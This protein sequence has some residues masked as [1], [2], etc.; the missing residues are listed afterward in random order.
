[1]SLGKLFHRTIRHARARLGR[2]APRGSRRRAALALVYGLFDRF[3]PRHLPGWYSLWPTRVPPLANDFTRAALQAF[4]AQHW[5]RLGSP[6]TTPLNPGTAARAVVELLLGRPDLRRRFPRSLQQGRDG[7]LARWLLGEE[8]RDSGISSCDAELMVEALGARPG[9]RILHWYDNDPNLRSRFPLARTPVEAPWFFFWLLNHGDNMPHGL[10]EDDG[11]G[12]LVDA[13]EDPAGG[14]ADSYLRQPLWQRM[15]PH[16]LTRFGWDELKAWVARRYNIAGDWL[17]EAERPDWLQ[18]AEE[19]HWLTV[20]RPELRARF[21]DVIVNPAS[22]RALAE[23][24][25]EQGAV[26]ADWLVRL[27]R[28]PPR[29]GVNVLAHFRYPSG[30]QVAAL[31]VL[32]G[33]EQA[34]LHPSRRDVPVSVRTDLPGRDGFLDLQPYPVSL[35]CLAPEP[36]AEDCY[37]RA[38]LAMRPG[39]YRIGYW[40]WELEEVPRRWRLHT[41]WLSE[42]W[43]PTRFVGDA[44]RRVMPLPVVDMLAGMRMPPVVDVPRAE[45]GLPKDRFL[46][47]FIFDMSSTF[48]R[49][50]PMAVVEAFRRAFPRRDSVALAVKVTR[51]Q[52]DPESL[53]KLRE[54]CDQVG[55]TLIDAMLSHEQLF[56]LINSCDAYVSLHRSEGYGLTMAEA[57]ALGKP[58]IA[59]GY[60]GNLDFMNEQNSLLVPYKKVAVRTT[61]HIYRKGCSWAEPSVDDAAAMM[62][63]VVDNPATAAQIAERG[64][65]D[66]QQ[67][68]S[69]EAAGRRMASRLAELER[70]GALPAAG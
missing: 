41:R 19:L 44:L 11:L 64:R 29:P 56:G 57:M 31:N 30:L 48:D 13:L 15:V 69:L 25:H 26:D 52:S 1:M 58:V 61:V 23:H 53:K 22:A 55:A 59:T 46:F 34:G 68:L 50:N 70:N 12:F 2:L 51:G 39:T 47:L 28:S 4:L 66:V 40:Y 37:P 18:P 10:A 16:G 45:L 20:A 62:R 60:S 67:I 8:A 27:N 43:A 54:A 3:S 65:R 5:V 17:R 36:L 32:T 49:K 38:G 24:L 9:W 63:W 14:L 33:L 42:L 35:V 21:P 6:P 7:P